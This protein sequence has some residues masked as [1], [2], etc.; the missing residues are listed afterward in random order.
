ML[1]Q[2]FNE[3]NY[4]PVD[5]NDN[6]ARVSKRRKT[7]STR[8]IDDDDGVY[9]AVLQGNKKKGGVGYAGDQKEDVSW[10]SLRYVNPMLI[11]PSTLGKWKRKPYSA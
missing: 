7:N 8:D 1:E 11:V 6:K 9:Y 3:Q 10:R 4:E 5:N 2:L